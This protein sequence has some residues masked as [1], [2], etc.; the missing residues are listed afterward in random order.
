VIAR[1]TQIAVTLGDMMEGSIAV[2]VVRIMTAVMIAMVV[3]STVTVVMTVMLPDELAVMVVVAST[4]EMVAVMA[5]MVVVV[6]A[7]VMLV[8]AIAVMMTVVRPGVAAVV[9]ALLLALLTLHARYVRNMVTLRVIVGGAT[10]IV[11]MM[12]MTPELSG[13]HMVLTQ[14]GT[15]TLAP[16][17]TSLES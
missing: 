1:P 9:D 7:T 12:R 15:W 17:I 3:V 5:V 11:M 2:M 14:T 16:L 8:G 6:L 10:L 13:E 4:A